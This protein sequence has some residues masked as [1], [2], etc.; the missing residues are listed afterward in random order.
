MQLIYESVFRWLQSVTISLLSAEIR[1]QSI[2]ISLKSTAIICNLLQSLCNEFEVSYN[3]FSI[4]CN[5]LA[6]SCN[7]LQSLRNQLQSVWNQRRSSATCC[8]H[9]AISLKLVTINFQLISSMQSVR[10]SPSKWYPADRSPDGGPR[11]ADS[12]SDWT[13]TIKWRYCKRWNFFRSNIWTS[14][15]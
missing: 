12:S 8:N 2:S 11:M 3:K 13:T 14:K 5:Q 4:N 10:K 6:I 1:S 15:W 7:Q 9:F